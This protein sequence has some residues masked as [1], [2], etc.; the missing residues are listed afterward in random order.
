MLD[1]RKLLFALV[2]VV[3]LTATPAFAHSG[4]VSESPP[5]TVAD[6]AHWDTMFVLSRGGKVL[7]I[8][9]SSPCVCDHNV[10][11]EAPSPLDGNMLAATRPG[12]TE[13]VET[14]S[15]AA[16]NATLRFYGLGPRE[17]ASV[18]FGDTSKVQGTIIAQCNFQYAHGLAI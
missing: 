14:V 11:P 2:V 7:M 17:T 6:V 10:S 3:A 4:F 5:Q 15:P 8:A 18:S 9:V 12:T 16:N 1:S 13:S